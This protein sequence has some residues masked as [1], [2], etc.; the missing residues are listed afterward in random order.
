MTIATASISQQL[1]PDTVQV[2]FT[3]KSGYTRY[4]EVPKQNAKPFSLSLINQQKDM[5]LNSNLVFF[6][7]MFAGIIGAAMLT[8]NME[9]RFM[10]FLIQTAS[11]IGLSF[12]SAL[13]MEKLLV[14]ER[15]DIENRF[16]AKE[17]FYNA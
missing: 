7:S 8:R 5:R 15:K 9:S 4:Y 12:F 13:G 3:T 17:L 14:N 2:D 10:Q 6:S 11:G 16:G 1:S